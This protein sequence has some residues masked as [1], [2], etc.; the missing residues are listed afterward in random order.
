MQPWL[1]V[2]WNTGQ[3]RPMSFIHLIMLLFSSPLTKSYPRGL[4]T[5]HARTTECSW[6]VAF[7]W[8]TGKR[9]AKNWALKLLGLMTF[10]VY[11]HMFG[12]ASGVRST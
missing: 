11:D 5:P 6:L 3:L 8:M 10:F 1:L 2:R 4:Y 12:G 7:A 9:S